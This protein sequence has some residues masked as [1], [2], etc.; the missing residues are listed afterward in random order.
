MNTRSPLRRNSSDIHRALET[1]KLGKMAVSFQMIQKSANFRSFPQPL[2]ICI[3]LNEHI[4]MVM[5]YTLRP[6]LKDVWLYTVVLTGTHLQLHHLSLYKRQHWLPSSPV[7]IP[8][9]QMAR[10]SWKGAHC[11]SNEGWIQLSQLW[12]FDRWHFVSSFL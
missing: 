11:T 4:K 7:T 9:S 2:I 6:V 8:C 3:I 1:G 5:C 12:G 10:F